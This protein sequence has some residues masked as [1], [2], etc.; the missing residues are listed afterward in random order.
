MAGVFGMLSVQL[1]AREECR[2]SQG[3]SEVCFEEGWGADYRARDPVH[4]EFGNIFVRTSRPGHLTRHSR[5]T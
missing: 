5:S 1:R 2:D 3:G 4:I